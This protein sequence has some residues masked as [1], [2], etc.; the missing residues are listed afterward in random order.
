MWNEALITWRKKGPRTFNDP[1]KVKTEHRE[2][3]GKDKHTVWIVLCHRDND[4]QGK[5][6]AVFSNNLQA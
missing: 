3:E 5:R 2:G 6:D 1:M 4:Y